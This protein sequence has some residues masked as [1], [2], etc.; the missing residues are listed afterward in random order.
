MLEMNMKKHLFYIIMF[1]TAGVH[2]QIRN[3]SFEVHVIKETLFSY[4]N[5]NPN[6]AASYLQGNGMYE[7]LYNSISFNN[8][9]NSDTVE[10]QKDIE[11]LHVISDSF[12]QLLSNKRIMVLVNDTIFPY[13]YMAKDYSNLKDEEEWKT[14]YAYLK[15]DFALNEM[16]RLKDTISAEFVDLIKRQID[17]QKAAYKI[18]LTN[19]NKGYYVFAVQPKK[20]QDTTYQFRGDKLYRPVFNKEF[21]K[22]CYLFSYSCRDGI[23]RDFIFIELRGGKWR[24]LDSYPSHLIGKED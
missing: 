2:G 5:D 24:Y 15:N 7:I 14:K 1:L 4:L 22:A 3:D 21:D 12:A 9:L 11:R 23:C 17:S 6:S 18:Y 16:V 8:K 20:N 13:N 10:L 19:L